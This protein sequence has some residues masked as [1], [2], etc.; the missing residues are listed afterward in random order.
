[1]GRFK[2]KRKKN[3]KAKG[4]EKRKEKLVKLSICGD[5]YILVM[6]SLEQ[7]CN[8]ILARDTHGNVESKKSNGYKR[9]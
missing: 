8:K 3:G 2:R 5:I 7:N 4:N 6:T 9:S 1:M